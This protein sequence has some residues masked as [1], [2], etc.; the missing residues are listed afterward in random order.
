[1][2]DIHKLLRFENIDFT[3]VI[4]YCVS[5]DN[6]YVIYRDLDNKLTKLNFDYYIFC[7]YKSD[8]LV[9]MFNKQFQLHLPDY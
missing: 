6:G 5:K 7:E 8:T 2:L 9:Y 4:E 1:M 3:E